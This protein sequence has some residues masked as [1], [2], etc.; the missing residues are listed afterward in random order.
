MKRIGSFLAVLAILAIA[1]PVQ[2]QTQIFFG[3][4]ATV[5]TSD[6]KDFDG[7]GA[8]TDGAKTGWQATAGVGFGLGESSA[9]IYARGFYGQ[10]SHDTDGD[11]TNP[12]GA[13]AGLT[14]QFG[15]GEGVAPFVGA[16]LGVLVHKFSSD[17][18]EGDSASEFA[19]EGIAGV[20]IPAGS[21]R[22]S[23]FGAYNGTSGTEHF[24]IGAVLGVPIG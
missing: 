22:V 17:A 19:W 13:M 3:G 1:A 23:L 8:G 4:M 7:D 20:R 18:S 12:Y 6:F 11:K 21:S 24:G 9:G 5:P 15:S 10:N 2:A 16:G 14:Y